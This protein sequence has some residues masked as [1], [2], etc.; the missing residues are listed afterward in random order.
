MKFVTF[1]PLQTLL[2]GELMY[3]FTRVFANEAIARVGAGEG[4]Q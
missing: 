4:H 1:E 3:S 2:P